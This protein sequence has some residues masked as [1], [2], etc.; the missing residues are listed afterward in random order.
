L[1]GDAHYALRL[2]IIVGGSTVIWVAVTLLTGPEPIEHLR[3]F[4]AR[5]RPRGGAWGPVAVGSASG[6]AGRDVLAWL[7]GVAFVYGA[8]F[9][10]GMLL[11]GP[12]LRGG[13]FLAGAAV[14]AVIM[15]RL[16]R[17][18]EEEPA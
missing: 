10:V 9:G 13:L 1:P 18:E 15:L 4:H 14:S 17:R 6:G 5:V 2:L 3:A 8:T 12:R 7:A 11:L 16:L